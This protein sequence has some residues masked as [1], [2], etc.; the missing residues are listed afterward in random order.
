MAIAS[1]IIANTAQAGDNDTFVLKAHSA[2]TANE[3]DIETL[4]S[5]VAAND[6]DAMN[7][8]KKEGR[9][10]ENMVAHLVVII[11]DFD[12]TNISFHFVGSTHVYWTNLMWLDNQ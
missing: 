11:G 10:A 5:L 6:H 1:L 2:Y 7:Q 3:A 12:G 9:A 4:M 8:M